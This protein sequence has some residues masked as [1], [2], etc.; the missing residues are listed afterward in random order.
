M[1]ENLKEEL[2]NVSDILYKGRLGE[3]FEA[4]GGLIPKL[5]QVAQEITDEDILGEYRD[6]CLT[7]MLEAMEEGDATA[8]ADIINY[9]LQDFL[10]KLV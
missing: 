7:P 8:L 10:D 2:T 9:E 3:G 5:L 6:E 1:I 4:V